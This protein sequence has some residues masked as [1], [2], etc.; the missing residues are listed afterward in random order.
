MP[1]HVLVEQ[2]RLLPLAAQLLGEGFARVDEIPADTD[3]GWSENLT[4]TWT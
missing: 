3:T 2:H 1:D 4:S